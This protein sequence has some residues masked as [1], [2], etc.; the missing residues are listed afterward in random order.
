M[1]AGDPEK[2]SQDGN[3]HRSSDSEQEVRHTYR[4]LGVVV[5]IVNRVPNRGSKM[6]KIKRDHGTVFR[7]ILPNTVSVV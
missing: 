6:C 3:N 7:R 1:V 2:F 4:G 5:E